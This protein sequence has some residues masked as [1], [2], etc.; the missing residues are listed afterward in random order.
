MMDRP[1]RRRQHPVDDH[2]V[3]VTGER[4]LRA[5]LGVVHDMLALAQALAQIVGRLPGV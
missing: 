1:S 2:H 5:L 3:V 4:E